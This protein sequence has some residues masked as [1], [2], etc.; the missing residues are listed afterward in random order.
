MKHKILVITL[1]DIII[2]HKKV[3][4]RIN[5]ACHFPV[6]M[7][8][9]GMLYHSE[10]LFLTLEHSDDTKIYKY[11]IAPLPSLDTDEITA[12]LSARAF[13]GFSFIGGFEYNDKLLVLY[14][15]KPEILDSSENK[16][17]LL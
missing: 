2:D 7:A 15:F 10:K 14:K 4:E 6:P 9:T 3:A 13:Y 5:N 16:Y 17:P 11:V 12:E 8:V 1:Q